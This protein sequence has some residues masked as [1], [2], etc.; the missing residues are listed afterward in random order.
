M[1]SLVVIPLPLTACSLAFDTADLNTYLSRLW[2][3]WP[4]LPCPWW[5]Y[6]L[7][8]SCVDV[9]VNLQARDDDMLVITCFISLVMMIL[10]YMSVM[11]ACSLFSPSVLT[12]LHARDDNTLYISRC[13]SL[14]WWSK[15]TFSWWLHALSLYM[16]IIIYM[17]VVITRSISF[18]RWCLFTCLWW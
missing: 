17:H 15:Y 2:Y 3:C 5:W 8:I 6:A 11:I 1:H 4:D 7:S 9:L 10:I 13:I 18:L 12:N 14:H 16:I